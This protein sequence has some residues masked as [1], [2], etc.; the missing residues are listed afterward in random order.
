[1]TTNHIRSLLVPF[2]LVIVL[3]VLLRCTDSDYPFGIFKPFFKI[4]INTTQWL[5]SETPIPV[6]FIIFT[7]NSDLD[8]IWRIALIPMY[9]FSPSHQI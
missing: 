3:S 7:I 2:P 5:M 8:S 1:M 4:P 9:C 6:T